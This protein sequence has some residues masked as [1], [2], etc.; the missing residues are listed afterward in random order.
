MNNPK[1]S[2]RGT[3]DWTS[4]FVGRFIWSIIPVLIIV[5]ASSFKPSLVPMGFVFAGAFAWMGTGCLLNALRCGRRHCFFTGPALWL[6][7]IGAAQIGL[8]VIPGIHALTTSYGA[9]WCSS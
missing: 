3:R 2:D 5:A 8:R 6:G 4:Q 9:L 1:S 7:V